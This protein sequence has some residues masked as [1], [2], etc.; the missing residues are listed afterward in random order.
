MNIFAVILIILIFILIFYVTTTVFLFRYAI[1]RKK[2]RHKKAK[3]HSENVKTVRRM[4]KGKTDKNN[5]L[6]SDFKTL[7]IT[8]FDGVMLSALYLPAENPK[9]TVILFHGFH[10]TPVW[11]F[12]ESFPYFSSLGFNLIYPFQRGHGKSGGKYVT[13]GIN[14]GHDAVLW[15]ETANSLLGCE[16]PIYVGGISL[17][18]TTVLMGAGVGYPDNVKGI[19]ADCGFISPHGIFTEVMKKSGLPPA[20]FVWLFGIL[21]RKIADFDIKGYSTLEALENTD[22]PIA[23]IHGECDKLIPCKTTLTVYNAYK[24]EKHLLTV[25]NAPHA[26][27]YSH[28]RTEYEAILKLLMKD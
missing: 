2:E 20:P 8:S 19:I 4:E 15:A 9:G 16:K 27:S 14:E 24:G 12:S 7:E 1:L 26:T 10:S 17:G 21:C 28:G 13:Y 23:F 25:K 5:F 22:I 3:K 11:D 18:C 6:S